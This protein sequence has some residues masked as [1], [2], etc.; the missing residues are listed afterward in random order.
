MTIDLSKFK[1]NEGGLLKKTD[2]TAKAEP[3]K[4]K[5]RRKP[6]EE[7]RT[8]TIS[9]NFTKREKANLIKLSENFAG[10]PLTNL[11]RKALKEQNYI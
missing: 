3:Q 1:K 4:P 11:I 10:V 2:Q 8:E 6:P 9:V 7:L 5:G